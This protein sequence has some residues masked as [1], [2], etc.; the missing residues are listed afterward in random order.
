MSARLIKFIYLI[1]KRLIINRL[2]LKP[3]QD[4]TSRGV[5]GC[6]STRTHWFAGSCLLLLSG[7][8]YFSTKKKQ[9][10]MIERD[11]SVLGLFVKRI[12]TSLHEDMMREFRGWLHLSSLGFTF[13][14]C[15]CTYTQSSIKLCKASFEL[16][17]SSLCCAGFCCA[18]LYYQRHTCFMFFSFIHFIFKEDGS[19]C[20]DPVDAAAAC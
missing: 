2:Y 17:V 9:N 8:E 5:V 4:L 1:C 6:D 11:D 12:Q 19:Q 14:M 15:M 3:W 7:R 16:R 18:W 20:S 10:V 13:E